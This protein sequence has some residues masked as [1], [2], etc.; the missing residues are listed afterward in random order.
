MCIY[1]HKDTLVTSEMTWRLTAGGNGAAPQDECVARADHQREPESP[2]LSHQVDPNHFP[3]LFQH[4]VPCAKVDLV[5]ALN[6]G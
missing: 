3:P 4:T 1:A 2:F 6:W 5:F